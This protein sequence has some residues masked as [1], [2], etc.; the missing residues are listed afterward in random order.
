MGLL[1]NFL[2]IN[3][4]DKAI[5]NLFLFLL[6]GPK[7]RRQYSKTIF[8]LKFELVNKLLLQI[9]KAKP[10]ISV[11]NTGARWN[12]NTWFFCV[13]ITFFQ[14]IYLEYNK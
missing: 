14:Q 2:K 4:N 9:E 13:L 6:Y 7:M 12:C 11:I 10:Q 5:H 3:E 1:E 8:F